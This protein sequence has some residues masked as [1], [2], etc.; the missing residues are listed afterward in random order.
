MAT[1]GQQGGQVAAGGAVLTTEQACERLQVSERTLRRLAKRHAVRRI[2]NGPPGGNGLVR[3]PVRE[4]DKLMDRMT[5][6]SR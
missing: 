3:W 4:I 6:V 2:K 1:S 5:R